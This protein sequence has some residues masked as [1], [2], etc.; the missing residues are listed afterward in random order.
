MANQRYK[1][2]TLQLCQVG[3]WCDGFNF[4]SLLVVYL[5]YR[6][7]C[8]INY[9]IPGVFPPQYIIH[10]C[11]LVRAARED[12]EK[13]E[14]RHKVEREKEEELSNITRDCRDEL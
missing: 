3:W 1:F 2:H 7:H 14:D 9:T 12:E 13:E 5:I 10:L 4:L 11:S 6:V 8:H